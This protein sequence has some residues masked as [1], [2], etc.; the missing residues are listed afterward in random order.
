MTIT[1]INTDDKKAIT[2][3]K[4]E[5]QYAV[6]NYAIEKDGWLDSYC[7][8]DSQ[9]CFVAKLDDEILGMF[10]FII[11]NENEF[12]V[13]INPNFLNKGYG[14]T[15]TSKAL[16]LA[17]N[18]LKFKEVSLIV[19]QNHPVAINLYKKLG[20]KITSENNEITNGE[21]IKFYKMLKSI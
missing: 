4:Y 11:E 16:E 5:D 20:F 15:L 18:D 6:F 3:W 21:S 8:N 12:R 9:Y 1:R 17:F 10:L 19:R 2:S 13:L 14:K 7:T